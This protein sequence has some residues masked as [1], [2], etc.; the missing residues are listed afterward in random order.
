MSTI[1]LELTAERHVI[2]HREADPRI[3]WTAC[4][5]RIADVG[6]RVHLRPHRCAEC[7]HGASSAR[8]ER[9]A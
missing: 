7:F 5:R 9:I 2:T 4:G 3:V 8:Q 6:R 1:V